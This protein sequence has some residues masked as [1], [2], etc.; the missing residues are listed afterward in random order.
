MAL[1]GGV[2]LL[3]GFLYHDI[4]W[5]KLLPSMLWITV[6]GVGLFAWFAALQM[7]LPNSR[8]ANLLTTLIIFPLL[9]MGGSFFPLDA[10]PDWLAAIGR[11]SPNGYVVERLSGELTS[12]SAWTFDARAWSTV[13][14][15]GVS[16]MLLCSWRLQSGFAR[17]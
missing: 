13:A 17:R 16:G 10:L 5:Q 2:P 7:M 1:I 12:A 6:A 8:A 11:L 14:A 4:A 9:M 3:L 15:I